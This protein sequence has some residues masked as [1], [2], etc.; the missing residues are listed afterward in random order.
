VLAFRQKPPIDIGA[1]YERQRIAP[2]Q[3]FELR[4]DA[5]Q[6]A[7]R[8]AVAAVDHQSRPAGFRRRVDLDELLDPRNNSGRPDAF[9]AN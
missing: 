6:P 3:L 1:D 8:E 7:G 4:L 9:L 2:V 5:R